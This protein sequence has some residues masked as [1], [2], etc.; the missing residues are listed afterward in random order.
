MKLLLNKYLFAFLSILFFEMSAFILPAGV[1]AQFET[2]NHPELKWETIETEH[3]NVHFH[4]GEYRTPRIIAKIAEEVYE[5]VPELVCFNSEGE[6][7]ALDYSKIS[8]VLLKAVQEQ[9]SLMDDL[10]INVAE[11]QA[12]IDNIKEELANLK[13]KLGE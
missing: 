13:S 5:V 6:I 2:Y 4:S 11:R 7:E 3:F 9:Q 8:V 1:Y 12:Q 10:N